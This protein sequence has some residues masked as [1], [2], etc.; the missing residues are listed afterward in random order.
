MNEIQFEKGDRVWSIRHQRWGVVQK[1]EGIY[2]ISSGVLVCFYEDK[3]TLIDPDWLV[4]EEIIIPPSARTRPKPKHEFKPGDPV[5]VRGDDQDWHLR[6]FDRE[7]DGRFLCYQGNADLEYDWLECVP[8][9]RTLLG[10][11]A[12]EEKNDE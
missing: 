11:D 10:F 12:V 2:G 6:A 1:R 8:Y 7:Q 4:F 9:D 5:C 3:D